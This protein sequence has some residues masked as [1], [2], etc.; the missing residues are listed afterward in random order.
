[1]AE[2]YCLVLEFDNLVEMRKLLEE[3]AN[4]YEGYIDGRIGY[5]FPSEYLIRENV[6]L[7]KSHKYVIS[8]L[9][10][11]VKTKCHELC[12][13]RFYCDERYR[14][15]WT[16]KWDSL[17]MN[18]RRKISRKFALMGYP[19]KVWVDEYQAYKQDRS[20]FLSQV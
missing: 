9:K 6:G 11:D 1:M 10:G 20:G 4:N 16:K 18:V 8:Y 3:S 13:A 12:H 14:K 7:K 15:L 19:E 5:N 17:N 2:E